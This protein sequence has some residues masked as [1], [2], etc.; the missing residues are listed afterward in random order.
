MPFGI[1]FHFFFL[2]LYWTTITTEIY[3]TDAQREWKLFLLT[4]MHWNLIGGDAIL[5]RL[6]WKKSDDILLLDCLKLSNLSLNLMSQVNRINSI[7]MMLLPTA[8]YISIA[9]NGNHSIV[10]VF[11]NVFLYKKMD[12]GRAG[13]H[14]WL[15]LCSW[16]FSSS[17]FIIIYLGKRK[18][19]ISMLSLSLSAGFQVSRI[20]CFF[21]NGQLLKHESLTNRIPT[22]NPKGICRWLRFFMSP[23]GR[24]I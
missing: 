20:F 3:L 5:S 17:L 14:Q 2:L 13:Y 12:I 18:E 1:L 6:N 8:W 7:A 22:G 24:K 23:K 9:Q 21:P 19:N 11:C 10:S 15:L 4:W 16:I